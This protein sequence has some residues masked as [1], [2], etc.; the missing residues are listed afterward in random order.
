M[1]DEVNLTMLQLNKFCC[2][3]P[4]RP[5]QPGTNT[6]SSLGGTIKGII[7]KFD[8][9]WQSMM[10]IMSEQ[11]TCLRTILPG[12]AEGGPSGFGRMSGGV[13]AVPRTADTISCTT[14]SCKSGKPATL[15]EVQ[16]RREFYPTF[17]SLVDE[18]GQVIPLEELQLAL[19]I[20]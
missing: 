1:N 2:S 6:K 11:E 16:F 14:A 20:F 8:C 15:R 17:L 9:C 3:E 7:R 10:M 18:V 12:E 19:N 5:T 4:F 13:A